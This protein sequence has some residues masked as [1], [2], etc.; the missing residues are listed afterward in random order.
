M[1][2][3]KIS[4][5]FCLLA[6]LNS[7]DHVTTTR[8]T[9]SVN[10]SA[11]NRN[12]VLYL[13]RFGVK[14]GRDVYLFGAA[15]R[16]CNKWVGLH[17]RMTLAFVPQAVWSDFYGTAK[18]PRS[19]A[20][21]QEVMNSTLLRHSKIVG[22]NTCAS[23]FKD[24]IRKLPC[25]PSDGDYI[26]CNQ[27]NSVGVV[28]HSN[29]T[30]H[31]RS[32]PNTEFYYIFIVACSRNASET[33]DWAVSDEVCFNYDIT[34]VN[35]DPTSPSKNHFDYH[36]PYEFHGVLILE[37]IFTLLYLTLVAIQIL[38][39]SRLV[40]GKGY[41][42]HLLIQ[43]FTTSLVL[44]LLHVTCEMIH[45][46]VYAANGVGVIAMKYFGEVFNQLS[47]W[48]LILV[49]ILVAKGWQV[50]TCTIRWKKLTS[51]AWGVYIFISGI[52]FVWMVVSVHISVMCSTST[53]VC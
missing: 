5:L 35:S 10:Y 30:Y 40:A 38:L 7:L 29:F 1:K 22:D 9:G 51:V 32:A 14:S 13:T 19:A 17:S 26:A 18:G 42:P 53:S 12:L 3:S 52:Y 37:M 34:V 6:G 24:Y 2:A 36:F 39:H 44:D 15:N 8:L 41:S 16:N 45:F 48:L 20:T 31:I 47:D 46:S 25:D 27:P 4:L 43:L 28:P 33:C 21:C 23:G 49:L 50:T 11:K